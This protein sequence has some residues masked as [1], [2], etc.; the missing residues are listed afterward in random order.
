M[1]LP[2]RSISSKWVFLSAN[3]YGAVQEQLCTL[4]THSWIC[5]RIVPE[6]HLAP[7][8]AMAR[9]KLQSRACTTVIYHS[10]QADTSTGTEEEGTTCRNQWMDGAITKCS[11]TLLSEVKRVKLCFQSCTGS[12]RQVHHGRLDHSPLRFTSAGPAR[13]WMCCSNSL[14]RSSPCYIAGWGML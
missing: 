2:I 4:V 5:S 9:H 12:F 10:A 8:S 6:N 13:Q 14:L 7:V 1:P 3:T 11:S